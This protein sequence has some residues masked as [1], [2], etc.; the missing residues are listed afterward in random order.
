MVA[1]KKDKN[2][3]NSIEGEMFVFIGDL[4][5][6]KA[7]SALDLGCMLAFIHFHLQSDEI[8]DR[9]SICDEVELLD[10]A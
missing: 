7:D 5:I 1:Y 3:C 2:F 4:K 6:F 9:N 8:V 10:L